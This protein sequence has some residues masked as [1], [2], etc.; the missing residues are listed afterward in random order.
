MPAELAVGLN[1]LRLEHPDPALSVRV[2]DNLLRLDETGE[3]DLVVTDRGPLDLELVTEQAQTIATYHADVPRPFLISAREPFLVGEESEFALDVT[4]NLASEEA[5]PVTVTCHREGGSAQMHELSLPPGRHTVTL[6]VPTGEGQEVT[7]EAEARVPIGVRGG[8]PYAPAP[9]DGDPPYGGLK[10]RHWFCVGVAREDF[11]NYREGVRELPT[12]RMYWAVVA[13]AVGYV[14]RRQAGSGAFGRVTRNQGSIW[15]QA[16]VYPVAL[17][18]K[19]EHPDNPFTGDRALLESAVLGMEFA[20]RPTV[21][22]EEHLHPDNRS[23]QA[24][25]LTYELLKDDIEPERRDYWAYELKHRA[26]GVVRRWLRPLEHR[27]ALHSADCGTG[28][29]HMAYHVANVYLAGE[30]FD[31]REWKELGRKFMRRLARHGPEGHFEER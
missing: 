10:A 31:N 7:V 16:F 20:L 6:P 18:Y 19:T 13:D 14:R 17:L 5:V 15:Q 30:V 22:M 24:Y 2:G 12:D 9:G 27:Y 29:N 25:L 3:F 1:R 4:L 28:T 26:E 8:V 21:S 23:L 11:D